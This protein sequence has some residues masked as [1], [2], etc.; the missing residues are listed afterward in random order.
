MTTQ[1]TAFSATAIAALRQEVGRE[2]TPL[3]T[4]YLSE[5]SGDAL[6]HWCLATGE[7]NPLYFDREYG[8]RSPYGTNLMPP[9]MLYAFNRLTLGY[10]GGLP[11]AR[12]LFGGVEWTWHRRV[13]AGDRLSSRLFFTDLQEMESKVGG[14]MFKQVSE[15]RFY[16]AEELVAEAL[17][18]GF[19]TDPAVL[20][21][22]KPYRDLAPAQ[23]TREELAG[24]REVYRQERAGRLPLR[25]WEDV[26]SEQPLPEMVRGPYTS[27]NAVA[28]M[29]AWGGQ[30]LRVHGD[31]LEHFLDRPA[32]AHWTA[33]GW[34]ENPS[35]GH[36][37]PEIAVQAG[38]PTSYDMGPERVAWSSQLF[39]NW[40]GDYGF[41]RRLAV[42]VRRVNPCGDVTRFSGRVTGKLPGG[43]VACEFE[44]RDQR[45][46]LT[47]QGTAEVVLPSRAEPGP[48]AWPQIEQ[49][50]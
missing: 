29:A 20:G 11:G 12:S 48:V 27:T 7:A 28:F 40:V 30:A 26:S 13:C 41:L 36:W 15:V 2:I 37:N 35:A 19:R 8:A 45:G 24:V 47:A 17:T 18:W 39:T 22:R 4:A 6:R 38:M 43:I 16:R 44:A 50:G 9:V 49:K 34:P 32:D 5:V 33:G 46:A 42:R 10:R 31:A 3:P 21:S 14:R 23:Y 1:N 25:C